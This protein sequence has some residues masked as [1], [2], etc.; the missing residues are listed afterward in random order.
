MNEIYAQ[1]DERQVDGD[2]VDKVE[3]NVEMMQSKNGEIESLWSIELIDRKEGRK[4]WKKRCQRNRAVRRVWSI[5]EN[6][7][8]RENSPGTCVCK[9][10]TVKREKMVAMFT[11][12]SDVCVWIKVL[13]SIEIKNLWIWLLLREEWIFCPSQH[14]KWSPCVL[15]CLSTAQ[16]FT[17]T[18]FDI[19]LRSSIDVSQKKTFLIRVMILIVKFV[20]FT[21]PTSD[22]QGDLE[23]SHVCQQCGPKKRSRQRCRCQTC[24]R[25]E[26]WSSHRCRSQECHLARSEHA[27]TQGEWKKLLLFLLWS[28]KSEKKNDDHNF[29]FSNRARKWPVL[30]NC[31]RT[32]TI[33]KI[34]SKFEMKWNSKR[35]TKCIRWNEAGVEAGFWVDGSDHR[36]RSMDMRLKGSTL[37]WS[38]WKA[39][40]PWDVI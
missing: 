33:R 37:S 38:G 28:N 39:S 29:S 11:Q 14:D 8:F 35:N 1:V 22:R 6:R 13:S 20:D 24:Q 19:Q 10:Y 12:M 3:T 40:W 31:R 32:K 26:P 36:T 18:K 25:F 16:L 23:G 21:I 27:H 34:W 15:P 17:W 4:E 7:S 2:S 30:N 9:V 5:C